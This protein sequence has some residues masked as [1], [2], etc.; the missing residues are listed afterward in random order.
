[1]PAAHSFRTRLRRFQV[2]ARRSIPPG[3]RLVLGILL[4]IGGFL[5]FLPIL[6]FWMLPLGIAIAALDVVPVW[7]R[8][9]SLRRPRRPR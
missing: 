4:I 5:G 2:Q 6:G 3:L 1:M 7:R 8:M 9:V